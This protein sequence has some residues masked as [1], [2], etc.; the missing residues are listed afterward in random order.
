MECV[1]CGYTTTIKQNWQRHLKSNRHR[2]ITGHACEC[3]NVYSALKSLTRHRKTCRRPTITEVVSQIAQEQATREE[4]IVQEQAAREERLAQEQATREERLAQ[5]QAKKF[6]Q[7][8]IA[9]EERHAAEIES[10]IAALATRPPP[11]PTTV[12]TNCSF[13]LSFFLNEQCK[14]A[15]TIEQFIGNIPIH[16]DSSIE[17]GQYFLDTL[18]KCAVEDR[19]IHCTDAKRGKMAVKTKPEYAD[20][21]PNLTPIWE[22]DRAKIDSLIKHNLNVLTGRFTTELLNGWCLQNPKYVEDGPVNDEFCRLIEMVGK[23]V[24][25]KFLRNLAK[26]TII[27][28]EETDNATKK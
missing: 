16:M 15:P 27:I 26:T 21:D 10:L 19:P 13:N 23:D 9:I 4:R 12:F 2:E 7:E 1:I 20:S 11:Q 18:A 25:E 6:T 22:Q 8:L 3:G 5:E 17:R 24:D 14:N 28:K